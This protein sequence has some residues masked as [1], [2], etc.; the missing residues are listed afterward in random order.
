MEFLALMVRPMLDANGQCIGRICIA[1]GAMQRWA[2]LSVIT[3]IGLRARYS[4]EFTG[5]LLGSSDVATWDDAE[6][7]GRSKTW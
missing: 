7:G 2:G 5:T 1:S 4:R 3:A 6:P